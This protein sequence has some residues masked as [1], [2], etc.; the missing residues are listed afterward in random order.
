MK[1]E[2]MEEIREE[3]RRLEVLYREI[4]DYDYDETAL[5][6]IAEAHEHLKNAY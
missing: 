5:W 6:H 4:Y 1:T 2:T 3:I